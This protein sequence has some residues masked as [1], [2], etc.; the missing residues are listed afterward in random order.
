MAQSVVV[1][2]GTP[3]CA[4][5]DGRV[6]V[7]AWRPVEDEPSSERA[8]LTLSLPCTRAGTPA[9]DATGVF[10]LRERVDETSGNAFAAWREL[11]RPASPTARELD[12]LR[13]C[14]RP[15]LEHSRLTA[16]GGRVT[17]RLPL[18]RQEVTF[19]EV[20]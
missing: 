5:P 16:T 14:E 1:V 9:P 15:A 3:V 6:T 17:L 10:V 13:A 2:R 19:V 20:T 7:L 18:S 8:E 4:D 12:Q 11:G